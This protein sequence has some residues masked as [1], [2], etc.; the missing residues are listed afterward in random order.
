M[1]DTKL[2]ALTALAAGPAETDEIYVRDVSE[3][4]ADESK[5][6][7]AVELLNPENFTELSATPAG[8]DELFI[9]D[10]GVGK[11]ISVTNLT[12]FGSVTEATQADMEDEG[13][14]NADRYVSPEVAKD[15]PS[16]AK[17]WGYVLANGSLQSPSYNVASTANT[18]TGTFTIEVG[19][20]FSSAIY[21][22]VVCPMDQGASNVPKEAHTSSPSAT[23]IPVITANHAGVADMPFAFVAFGDHA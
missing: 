9:N 14:S 21:A 16:A 13:T 19:T 15:A 10:G 17:M 2:S 1:A 23:V 4:A 8:T 20:D 11:K 5:R 3:S 12:N 22:I 18:G 6:I 7:T